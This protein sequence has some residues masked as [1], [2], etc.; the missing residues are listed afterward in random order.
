MPADPGLPVPERRTD[1]AASADIRRRL[2][3]ILVA[4]GGPA[5]AIMVLYGLTQRVRVLA[6]IGG[7]L[8]VV[9]LFL[10]W[11]RR[12]SLDATAEEIRRNPFKPDRGPKE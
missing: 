7:V 3:F 6:V 8:L 9:A 4:L 5:G 11:R 10:W 1:L 2:L 12:A